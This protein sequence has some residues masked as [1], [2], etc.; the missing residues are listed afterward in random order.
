MIQLTEQMKQDINGA[1]EGG[2]PIAVSAVTPESEPA[3]SYRRTTQAYGDDALAFWV[4][5]REDSV[6]LRAIAVHPV[7]VA[8]YTNMT[9]WRHYMFTGRA[10]VDADPRVRDTVFEN[11]PAAEQER[12]PERRGVA[13]IVELE[14]VRGRGAEG[15]VRMSREG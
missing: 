8:V 10:R 2:H 1:F 7:V 9:E 6:T 4:R 13:V 11:S 12:D 15:P 5:N 3:V 14:S